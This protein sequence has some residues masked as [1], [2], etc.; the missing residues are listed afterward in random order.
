MRSPAPIERS[1][2]LVIDA[3]DSFAALPCWE[4]R[5]NPGFEANLALLV[6]A[7]H[8]AGLPI[9][10]FLHSDDDAGF[11]RTSPHY[12][13][14]DAVA[15]SADEPLLHKTTRNCFTSTDLQRR[16]VAGDYG[17]DVD[18]VTDAT[19]TFPIAGPGGELGTD[20]IVERTE[21]A[22]RGRFARIATTAAIV[23]DVRAREAVCRA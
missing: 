16:L 9:F 5:S 6:Q 19:R 11:E 22:L 13:V 10:F 20:A 3:Q 18:F 12:R 15:P 7:H 1:A 8:T 21:Y 2:L 14:M 4:R 23:A 17:Y